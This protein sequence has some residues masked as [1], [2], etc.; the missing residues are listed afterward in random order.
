MHTRPILSK[1]CDLEKAIISA[2]KWSGPENFITY[3]DKKSEKH[4]LRR[5]CP[6]DTDVNETGLCWL[7][8]FFDIYGNELVPYEDEW[9]NENPDCNHDPE[10]QKDKFVCSKCNGW[11]PLDKCIP[12]EKN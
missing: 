4:V 7:T 9:I 6:C 5:R 12:Q 1:D 2:E 8:E 11:I 3:Y 10:P